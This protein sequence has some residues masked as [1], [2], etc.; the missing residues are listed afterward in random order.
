MADRNGAVVREDLE[1]RSPIRAEELDHLRERPIDLAVDLFR[2]NAREARREVGQQRSEAGVVVHTDKLQRAAESASP[3]RSRN[4]LARHSHCADPVTVRITVIEGRPLRR[5]RIEGR[6][7]GD[8]VGELEQLLGTD[9]SAACL[10]LSEL[11]SVD[12]AAAGL[13][14]R[15]RARGF[16]LHELPP[17]L[18]WRLEGEER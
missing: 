13:L 7:S 5:L 11:R 1:E 3:R 17:Q 15:L 4:R 16:A 9:P 14:R 2:G 12:A 18:A 8:A 6:L 10:E